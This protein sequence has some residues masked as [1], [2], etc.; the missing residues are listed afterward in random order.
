[1]HIIP[2]YLV[3]RRAGSYQLEITDLSDRVVA[4]ENLDVELK[5]KLETLLGS[6]SVIIESGWE[7]VY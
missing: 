1:M 4:L 7:P 2:D 3:F 6:N 5:A